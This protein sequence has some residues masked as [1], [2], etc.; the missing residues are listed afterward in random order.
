MTMLNM[1]MEMKVADVMSRSAVAIGQN[2]RVPEIVGLLVKHRRSSLPVVDDQGHIIGIIS[3]ADLLGALRN[4]TKEAPPIGSAVSRYGSRHPRGQIAGDVMRRNVVAV[5]EDTPVTSLPEHFKTHGLRQIPVIRDKMIIGSVDQHSLLKA[6]IA[7]SESSVDKDPA[8]NV[9]EDEFM[10]LFSANQ[11][12][13]GAGPHSFG[14][15]SWSFPF[16]TW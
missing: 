2:A 15:V 12:G 5:T 7:L 14:S 16:F 9:Q 10:D 3:E 6:L 4:K 8:K 1:K 11:T 13:I